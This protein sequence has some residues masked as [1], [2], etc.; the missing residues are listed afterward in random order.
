M[1]KFRRLNQILLEYYVEKTCG[2]STPK[3]DISKATVTVID[4][5]IQMFVLSLTF[6]N[7]KKLSALSWTNNQ[8]SWT[9]IETKNGNSLDISNLLNNFDVEIFL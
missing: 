8:S 6:F 2:G 5:K 4:S 7:K 3:V 9:I 1:L